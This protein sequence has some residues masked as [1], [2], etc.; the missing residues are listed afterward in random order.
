MVVEPVFSQIKQAQRI[1]R[2][3]F[4]GLP[5]VAAEWKLICVTHNLLSLFRQSRQVISARV[6][7][8]INFGNAFLAQPS[9]G[10]YPHLLLSLNLSESPQ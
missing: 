4:R 5:K 7:I 9:W 3:S 8:E 2:F 10:N 6:E 1:R